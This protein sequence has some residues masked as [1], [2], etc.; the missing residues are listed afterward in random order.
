MAEPAQPST[1]PPIIVA[2]TGTSVD[3]LRDSLQGAYSL[4]CAQ[5]MAQAQRLVLPETPLVLC[6][7]QFDD[8]RMYDL[9]RYMKATP[10]LSTVP[11]MAI[12]VRE[13]KLD[14]AMYESVK[15]A[16]RALGANGF[17]DLFRWQLRYGEAEA[18]HRLTQCIEALARGREGGLSS[19]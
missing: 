6:D 12:R 14:D 7:C 18:R 5:T 16:T 13:G 8:G 9:L 4:A 15:I 19:Q 1:W 10:A 3:V 11:F 17:V 2:D